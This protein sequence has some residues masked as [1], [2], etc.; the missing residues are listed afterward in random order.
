LLAILEDYPRDELFQA[1]VDTLVD[2]T[3]DIQHLAQR[4]RSKLFLRSDQFGRFVSALVY[5]PRDRYN[6]TVRLRIEAMLREAIGAEQVDHTTR[7]S[8]STLAHLHFVLRLPKDASIPDLDMDDGQARVADAARTG[9]E[10]LLAELHQQHEQEAGM[11]FARGFPEA[12]TEDIDAHAALTGLAE[13]NA[14][15]PGQTRVHLYTPEA[16][17]NAQRRIKIYRSD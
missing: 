1:D 4:R 11:R 3:E 13:L 8:E 15:A 14:V 6:T 5:L 7:V 10:N 2:V 17:D 9:E 16:G 12:Y